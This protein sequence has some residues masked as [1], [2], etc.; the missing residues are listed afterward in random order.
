[1]IEYLKAIILAVFTGVTAPLPVSSSAHFNFLSN[2]LG[3]SDNSEVISLYYSGFLVAF[4]IVIIISF[5][6]IFKGCIKSI[7]VSKKNE[8]A[9]AASSGFRFIL[10]NI[11][12][13]IIPTLVLL[14][15]VS[16][17]KLMMDLFDNFLN[18]N[19][20]ILSG[21]A[22]VISACILVIALWYSKKKDPHEESASVKTALRLSLYQ[23][24][25]YIVPGFSHIASG[26]TN[27]TVCDV[28]SKTFLS[29]L[30]VYLA[31][32][33]LIVGLVKIIRTIASG[34]LFDPIVMIVGMVFFAI[35]CKFVI[36]LTAK[37][38]LRRLFSFFC[39]YS[40]IFGVFI[41]VASFYI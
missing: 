25:C 22:C 10:K 20:V 14:V 29:E 1:M 24:P 2:V 23:L 4:A 40:V 3:F 28:K 5:R 35:A 15:P 6:K 8:E 33:M 31:P 9:Y 21:F 13:S 17:D 41:A 34:L 37:T 38:N 26:V 19:S 30:Y 27:L 18:L 36:S 12:V 16:K 11:C 32:S 39:A 7:F